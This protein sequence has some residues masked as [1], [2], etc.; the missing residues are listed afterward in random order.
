MD[1]NNLVEDF[2]RKQKKMNELRAMKDPIYFKSLEHQKF[3]EA[4]MNKSKNQDSYHKAL[5]YTLGI[6]EESR[7]HIDEIF[8][9]ENDSIKISCLK[10]EW[11]TS[12]SKRAIYLAFN[13]YTDGFPTIYEDTN[14]NDIYSEALEYSVSYI[15]IDEEGYYFVEAIRLRNFMV[16]KEYALINSS[17]LGRND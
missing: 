16:C 12:S 3:Y 9:F 2:L 14:K 15:F 13:L 11:V 7:K 6:N 8:D 10:K 5:F 17:M 4:C 1:R